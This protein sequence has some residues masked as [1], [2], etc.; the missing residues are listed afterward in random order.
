MYR[1]EFK[2]KLTVRDIFEHPRISEFAGLVETQAV[3][4]SNT[5]ARDDDLA[6]FQP[7]ALMGS[8]NI[9]AIKKPAAAALG[10]SENMIQDVYPCIALQE[11]L[12]A[13]TSLTPQA[14]V[15]IKTF[16]LENFVDISQLRRA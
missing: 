7:F 16:E 4:D 10:V 11:G 15:A 1:R 3:I 2:T 13:S 5:N 14:Y 8:G 6:M 12:L 9:D